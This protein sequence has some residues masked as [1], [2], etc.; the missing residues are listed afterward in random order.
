MCREKGTVDI[1]GVQARVMESD[2][3]T[4]VLLDGCNGVGVVSMRSSHESRL[5]KPSDP[6]FIVDWVQSS[7][8]TRNRSHGLSAVEIDAV[9][10][11][12]HF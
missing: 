4:S 9:R 5:A 11:I 2:S 3:G 12:V 8:I 6:P 10:E 7:E 1:G